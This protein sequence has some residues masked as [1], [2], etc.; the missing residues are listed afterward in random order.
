[1]SDE[2]W[3]DKA[4][5]NWE[6]IPDELEEWIRTPDPRFAA[7]REAAK[8]EGFRQMLNQQCNQCG[9][10]PIYTDHACAEPVAASP[11]FYEL[12]C[13]GCQVPLMRIGK[14]ETVGPVRTVVALC[15]VCYDRQAES[16]AASLSALAAWSRR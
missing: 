1:V 15:A 14:V 3:A 5:I 11:T 2:R 16:K 7:V 9:E 10:A 4:P 12:N 13:S 8:V 6:E